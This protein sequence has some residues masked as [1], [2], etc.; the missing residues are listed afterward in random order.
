MKLLLNFTF[1]VSLETWFNSGYLTRE[2]ALYKKLLEKDFDITFLTYGGKKDLSYSKLLNGIDIIPAFISTKSKSHKINFLKSFILPLKLKNTF[3]NVD[4]I[5]TNQLRGSWVGWIAKILYGKKLI[6]RGG[7][8][9]LRNYA[10]NY[11]ISSKI[12][13]KKSYLRYLLTILK[14]YIFEYI[15]YK[16]ADAIIL[17][18]YSD[19]NFIIKKFKLKKKVHNIHHFP[20]PI[21]AELFKPLKIEKK[22]K[23]VLFVG[24]LYFVKNLVNLVEGFRDLKEFSLDIVGEGPQKELLKKKAKDLGININ[25]LGIIPNE[26]L[27]EIINQYQIFILPSYYEGNPKVLLEAMSCGLACIG[28]DVK[29]I[30]NIL[31]HMENGL[32]CKTDSKSIKNAIITLYNNKNLRIKFGHNARQFILNNCSL[33]LIAKKE[34]L[35]YKSLFK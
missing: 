32:L 28:T 29:G 4:I 9:W 11:A 24:T 3:K 30:N 23:H 33:N 10:K 16:L 31:K 15:A 27:P 34:Y 14:I 26:Q 13:G 19:I 20:N 5:K 12:R 8:E 6:I 25:F 17:T 2:I 1:N 18:S 21:D 35:L 7:Y 22:D